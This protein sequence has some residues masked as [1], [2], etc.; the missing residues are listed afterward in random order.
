MDERKRRHKLFQRLF[1]WWYFSLSWWITSSCPPETLIITLKERRMAAE[2]LWCTLAVVV[3]VRWTEATAFYSSWG[4]KLW[5][6]KRLHH[7]QHAASASHRRCIIIQYENNLATQ[8]FPCEAGI[9]RSYQQNSTDTT[10]LCPWV[11]S[12]QSKLLCVVSLDRFVSKSEPS[13][14]WER[15][16]WAIKE[17][18]K[19]RTTRIYYISALIHWEY[20]LR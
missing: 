12:K 19:K 17:E 9:S 6:Q 4:W 2:R 10:R 7:M 20:Q 13:F 3:M 15:A 8:Y 16:C 1:A 14:L 5:G 11:E 18:T